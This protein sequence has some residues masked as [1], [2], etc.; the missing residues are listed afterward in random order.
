MENISTLIIS[1][2]I[3]CSVFLLILRYPSKATFLLAFTIPLS[4]YIALS[5]LAYASYGYLLFSLSDL[6]ISGLLVSILLNFCLQKKSLIEYPLLRV[7]IAILVLYFCLLVLTGLIR[8]INEFMFQLFYLLRYGLYFMI[9]FYVWKYLPIKNIEKYII[10]LLSGLLINSF[11]AIYDFIESVLHERYLQ[12]ALVPRVSGFWGIIWGAEGYHPEIGDAINFAMYLLISLI[13]NILYLFYKRP[14][15]KGIKRKLAIV[16]LFFGFIALHMTMSRAAIYAF[17][18][19]CL[20]LLIFDGKMH[21]KKK[22]IL[23]FSLIFIVSIFIA[24]YIGVDLMGF[25]ITRLF[26]QTSSELTPQGLRFG[27]TIDI[28]KYMLTTFT[29]WWGHGISSQRYYVDALFEKGVIRYKS[30]SL[31]NGYVGLF[32]DTGV[33]GMIVWTFWVKR[34]FTL[35]SRIKKRVKDIDWLATS[36]KA[37]LIGFLI[38]MLSTDFYRNFRVMGYF[39]FLMGLLLKSAYQNFVTMAPSKCEKI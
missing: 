39:S 25:L 16:S 15:P 24:Y 27:L 22:I 34:H 21:F 7:N 38:G 1:L 33:I 8:P 23:F 26:F 14:S 36:M 13:G 29:Q 10:I 11:Y 19:A 4:P 31:Y 37:V 28:L 20:Y 5:E 32:W 3:L 6:V 35:F 18:L 12:Y 17:W 9:G 2:L 30:Y